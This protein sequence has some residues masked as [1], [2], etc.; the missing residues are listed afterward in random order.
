MLFGYSGLAPASLR[1]DMILVSTLNGPIRAATPIRD[2][3]FWA[4]QSFQ[5]DNAS[6]T[7]S[8]IQALSAAVRIY[9]S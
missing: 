5:T 3:S 1:A 8:S 4:A 2:P 6:H 9:R 7:L